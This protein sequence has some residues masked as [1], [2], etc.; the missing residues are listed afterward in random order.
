LAVDD[1][2]LA[3]ADGDEGKLRV[4]VKEKTIV[5]GHSFGVATA[6]HDRLCKYR[7]EDAA[8]SGAWSQFL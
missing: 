3:P 4:R 8:E 7:K 5:N 2:L 6:E 1:L